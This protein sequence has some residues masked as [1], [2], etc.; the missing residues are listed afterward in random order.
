MAKLSNTNSEFSFDKKEVSVI[1]NLIVKIAIIIIEINDNQEVRPG[2]ASLQLSELKT[3][4]YHAI[5]K[6]KGIIYIL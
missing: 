6:N 5:V 4:T 3:T 1:Y 2:K